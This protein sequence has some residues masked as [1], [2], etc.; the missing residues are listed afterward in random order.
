MG[1]AVRENA[2]RYLFVSGVVMPSGSG[3]EERDLGWNGIKSAMRRG[4]SQRVLDVGIIG[5]NASGVHEDSDLTNAQIATIHE[6][7]GKDNRPPERSFIRETIDKKR[8]TYIRKMEQ[9]A[10][11]FFEKK[12]SL[13]KGLGLLGEKVQGDIKRWMKSGIPPPLA[14]S[15]INAKTVAGKKKT[16]PLID[17]GQLWGSITYVVRKPT[18]K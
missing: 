10:R 14:D 15:T 5:D 7:G 4:V 1:Q 18:D 9:I 8:Q 16:V 13:T 3:F 6:F 11:L 2:T 12:M 17:T